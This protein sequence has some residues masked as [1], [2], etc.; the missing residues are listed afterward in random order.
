MRVDAYNK[1]SQLYQTNNTKKVTKTPGTA[2]SDQ[3]QISQTGKDYQFAKQAVA[4]VPD[5]RMDKIN[6]IKNRMESG[7]YNISAEEVANKITDSYF[8]TKI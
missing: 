1:I 6:D 3:V 4:A 2:S 8:N 5:L 7:T